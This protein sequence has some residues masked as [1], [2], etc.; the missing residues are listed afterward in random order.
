MKGNTNKKR[1]PRAEGSGKP[2]QQIEV[3][4]QKTNLTTQYESILQADT[5]LGI[6]HYIILKYLKLGILINTDTSFKNS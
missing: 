1:K 2:S 4:D 5:A 6:V 3:T